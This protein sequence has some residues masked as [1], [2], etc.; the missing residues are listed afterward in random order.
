MDD[1]RLFPSSE[2]AR[3]QFAQPQP[4]QPVGK[5]AWVIISLLSLS[6]QNVTTRSEADGEVVAWK[7]S[8]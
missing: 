6:A 4:L 1:V 2:R 3:V 8:G 5:E 7:S